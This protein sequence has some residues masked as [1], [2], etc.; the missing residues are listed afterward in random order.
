MTQTEV[1]EYIKRLYDAGCVRLSGSRE[2]DRSIFETNLTEAIVLGKQETNTN[3]YPESAKSYGL[4]PIPLSKVLLPKAESDLAFSR[5]AVFHGLFGMHKLGQLEDQNYRTWCD[6]F[7][8][9]K[10]EAEV[11]AMVAEFNKYRISKAQSQLCAE[12]IKF[13]DQETNKATG[14]P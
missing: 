13:L 14:T 12:R 4:G 9:C 6:R 10:S 11:E 1:L 2:M 3:K 8:A 5:N 7:W